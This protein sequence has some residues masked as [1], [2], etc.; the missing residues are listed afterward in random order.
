M[1]LTDHEWQHKFLSQCMIP[2]L[3][4]V[5][6]AQPIP[7]PDILGLDSRTRNLEIPLALQMVDHDGITPA[8]P[9]AMQ[10]AML[11]STRHVSE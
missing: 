8:H 10:Q 5:A 1:S 7:Y 6:S 11:S 2:V 3:D 4:A 9:L